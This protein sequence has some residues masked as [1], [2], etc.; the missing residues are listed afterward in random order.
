MT[1]YG[2]VIISGIAVVGALL[3]SLWPLSYYFHRPRPGIVHYPWCLLKQVSILWDFLFKVKPACDV[4]AA[5]RCE[6]KAVICVLG[7]G[8]KGERPVNV[9][10]P[11]PP[12]HPLKPPQLLL[13]GRQ[14]SL[15]Q[16]NS[17]SSSFASSP[18]KVL[19]V[20]QQKEKRAGPLQAEQLKTLLSSSPENSSG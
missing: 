10:P 8:G 7:R 4:C 12:V 17:L 20:L 5:A 3:E 16:L 6:P 1:T 13:Y 19:Q 14:S 2:S 15:W 18:A 9:L 11:L